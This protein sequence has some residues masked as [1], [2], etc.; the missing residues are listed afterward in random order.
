M[1]FGKKRRGNS[2]RDVGRY[3]SRELR[4]KAPARRTRN[5]DWLNDN[6]LVFAG[7]IGTAIAAWLRYPTVIGWLVLAAAP[8]YF[9][10]IVTHFS[11]VSAIE[12]NLDLKWKVLCLFDVLFRISIPGLA[13]VSVYD[14]AKLLFAKDPKLVKIEERDAYMAQVTLVFLT[15]CNLIVA[16][17]ATI[18]GLADD[19][20]LENQFVWLILSILGPFVF[21]MSVRGMA[22]SFKG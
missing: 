13:I 19:S 4:H 11:N 6:L 17:W 9:V 5:L 2:N 20:S 8:S 15:C 10:T 3:K 14:R 21:F 16:G 7:G 1:S 12:G 22:K 18:I